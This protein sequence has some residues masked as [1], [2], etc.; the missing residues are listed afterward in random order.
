MRPVLHE[1]FPDH[2]IRCS[3]PVRWPPHLTPLEFLFLWGTIKHKVYQEPPTKPKE[4][5][6]RIIA[7]SAAVNTSNTPIC[8]SLLNSTVSK[9]YQSQWS[10]LRILITITFV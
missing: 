1:Q 8:E 5:Q 4:M 2:W 9:V 7:A 6:Q 10:P 3:G